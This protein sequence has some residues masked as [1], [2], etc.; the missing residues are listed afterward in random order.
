[1]THWGWAR[2]GND[3]PAVRVLVTAWPSFLHGEATAGDVL[4]M[5]AVRGALTAADIRCDLAWSPVFRPRRPHPG[6]RLARGLLAPGVRVRAAA[7]EHQRA[8][9]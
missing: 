5:N 8:G 4:A 2:P 9:L 1:M 6:R 3:P 7:R